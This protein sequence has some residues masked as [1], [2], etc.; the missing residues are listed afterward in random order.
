MS[1]FGLVFLFWFPF[2]FFVCFFLSF[3]VFVCRHSHSLGTVSVSPC[4]LCHPLSLS[5]SLTLSHSLTLSLSLPP[6]S[7]ALLTTG[8]LVAVSPT[9]RPVEP[10]HNLHMLPSLMWPDQLSKGPV[11]I[12]QPVLRKNKRRLR[13]RRGTSHSVRRRV[14][15]PS[16]FSLV[17]SNT[18]CAC[19]DCD[20]VPQRDWKARL[21]AHAV[22]A[23]IDTMQLF[24]VLQD[25]TNG[26]NVSPPYITTATGQLLKL[27]WTHHA[28]Q[29]IIHSSTVVPDPHV[30]RTPATVMGSLNSSEA[31]GTGAGA[32]AGA[33]RGAGA[34]A[35]SGPAVSTHPGTSAGANHRPRRARASGRDAMLLPSPD[36]PAGAATR[37]PD[38]DGEAETEADA[39]A[40]GGWSP[41][42]RT[43]RR[44][45]DRTAK[46]GEPP[47]SD[48]DSSDAAAVATADQPGDV[49]HD[50]PR[51][52]RT[53]SG[54]AKGKEAPHPSLPLPLPRQSF[55]EAVTSG[56]E[57]HAPTGPAPDL[58][59]ADM[60]R[61]HRTID[62]FYFPFG[63]VVFWGLQEADEHTLL[64]S[65][66][67]NGFQQQEVIDGDDDNME[68]AFGP[69]FKC[70]NDKV[71]LATN[72]AEEK[73]AVSY[74]L[75]Q[76]V[77]L[78]VAEM[79]VAKTIESTSG[80]W[81]GCCGVGISWNA[82][83]SLVS[84]LFVFFSGASN[85]AL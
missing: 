25:P 73:L 45:A 33:G 3:S 66:K 80:G 31:A 12:E 39:D 55:P 41:D 19:F 1:F 54:E 72:D 9:T 84:F 42:D 67:R 75:A 78:S 63:V 62:I 52:R 77:L 53:K 44:S 18:V 7:A 83:P 28:L 58:S 24:E 47:S 11:L 29:D 49:S 15:L 68:F 13:L 26:F 65:L 50:R 82:C 37:W 30:A 2:V 40:D 17:P 48:S 69:S 34:G 79:R 10:R 36:A 81:C 46:D 51:S 43:S 38:A 21:S 22:C 56:D 32:G 71:T 64:H 61:L 20:G 6:S 35:G 5:L 27:Q 8:R 57:S 60:G 16:S 76:S 23:S 85:A 14:F 59:S 74:A 4:S 70:Y